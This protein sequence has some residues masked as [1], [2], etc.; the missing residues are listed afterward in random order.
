MHFDCREYCGSEEM[1]T[2]IKTG[3]KD[4]ECNMGL[5]VYMEKSDSFEKR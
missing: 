3:L 1:I 2:R 5:K 4:V